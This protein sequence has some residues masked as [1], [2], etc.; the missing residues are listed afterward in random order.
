[1]K[2]N[3]LAEIKKIDASEIKDKVKKFRKEVAGLVLDKNTG[4]LANLKNI[5]S[6]R[7]DIAQMLTVLRQ[8]ELLEKFEKPEEI[9]ET[10]NGK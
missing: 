2:R 4:K 1:M 5:K 8:K 10:K 7:R 3:D 6:K 9:K